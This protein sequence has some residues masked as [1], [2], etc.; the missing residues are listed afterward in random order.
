LTGG[1]TA[2]AYTLSAATNNAVP[3][4]PTLFLTDPTLNPPAA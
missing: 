4:L 1:L 2:V 3:L